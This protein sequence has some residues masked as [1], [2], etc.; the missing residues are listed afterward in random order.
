MFALEFFFIKNITY[1]LHLIMSV[2]NKIN[3][4]NNYHN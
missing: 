2:A 4:I 3:V 1:C